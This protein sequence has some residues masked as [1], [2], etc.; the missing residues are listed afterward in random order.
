MDITTTAGTQHFR[1][2]I[3]STG[4]LGHM[5]DFDAAG[6]YTAGELL[7][8][9]TTAFSTSKVT[10]NYAF[11]FSSV[12]NTAPSSGGKTAIA[13]VLDLSTGTVS[14]GGQWDINDEG[15]V[16]GNPT[17][18]FS[19]C[20]PYSFS[21]GSYT[22]DATSGRGTIT[23]TASMGGS[24]KTLDAV[25][26]VVSANQV[27]VLSSDDQ[28][29]GT[30]IV[31]GG[32]ALKQT[33]P[34]SNSSANGTS[35]FYLS[36]PNGTLSFPSGA[37]TNVGTA[38][39]NG[40]G[41]ITI[42]LW[43]NSSGTLQCGPKAAPNCSVNATYAVSSSGRTVISGAGNHPP[44]IYLVSSNEG[45]MLGGGSGADTGFLQPQSST[46]VS[47]TYAVGTIDP[48]TPNSGVSDAIVTFSGGSV[49]G[50]NDNNS[51]GG[52]STKPIPSTSVSVDST[53]FGQV[54]ASCTTGGG[55]QF[56]FYV[57]SPKS[58]VGTDGSSTDPTVQ[59]VDQ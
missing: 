41:G 22:I 40:L 32:T 35:I 56:L 6:P 31:F 11:L 53:G 48:E 44:L 52:P 16:D 9:D 36:A 45:F 39:A 4:T 1:A 54:A 47:G 5:I 59:T 29:A 13:G 26:Y 34:F 12:Q 23:F 2:T 24:S 27:L 28:A 51:P 19:T 46:S 49:S 37:T 33:G 25:L 21:G 20:G 38:K 57:I 58:A 15:T 8:Q 14:S 43:Q 50:T 10:G 30:N 3:N 7:K 18:S 42:Y 17:C 55:C